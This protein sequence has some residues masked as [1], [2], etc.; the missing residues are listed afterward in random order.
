MPI[1]QAVMDYQ[2]PQVAV[3]HLV[4]VQRKSEMS[5]PKKKFLQ[6][7]M[8]EALLGQRNQETCF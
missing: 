7:S 2:E 5:R 4:V 3:L 1:L 8:R 6:E